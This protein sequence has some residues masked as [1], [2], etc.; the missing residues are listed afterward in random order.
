MFAKELESCST[1]SARPLLSNLVRYEL[2]SVSR[3]VSQLCRLVFDRKH[4][5]V[6]KFNLLS[7][8]GR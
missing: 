8:S 1:F 7:Q 3:W 2:T 4:A 6:K 5:I